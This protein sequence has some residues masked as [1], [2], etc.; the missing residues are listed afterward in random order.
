ME[1]KMWL[2]KFGDQDYVAYPR[3]SQAEIYAAGFS[4]PSEAQIIGG[5]FVTEDT[6]NQKDPAD[7]SNCKK[8]CFVSR[9]DCPEN[10]PDFE[11]K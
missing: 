6:P 4:I 10:Y 3:K 7:Y 8:D 9:L 2:V 1:I 5:R 11:L